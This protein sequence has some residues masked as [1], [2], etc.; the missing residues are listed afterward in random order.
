M[1]KKSFFK[2]IF[3]HDQT[4]SFAYSSCFTLHTSYKNG[5]ISQIGEGCQDAQKQFI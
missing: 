3:P 5:M 4:Y 2:V 1:N